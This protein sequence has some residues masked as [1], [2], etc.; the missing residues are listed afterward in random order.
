MRSARP[1]PRISV[2]RHAQRTGR[3]AAKVPAP[4]WNIRT[5]TPLKCLHHNML[6]TTALCA[7]LA[8]EPETA[9]ADRRTFRNSCPRA[10]ALTSPADGRRA[11]RIYPVGDHV[12]PDAVRPLLAGAPATEF[13]CYR[14]RRYR[15]FSGRS[16]RPADRGTVD[17]RRHPNWRK[18][19]GGLLL[20]DGLLPG[21][22]GWAGRAEGEQAGSCSYWL[23][24]LKDRL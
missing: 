12:P 14:E 1:H 10:C 16:A 13:S 4:A 11:G 3:V 23:D 22:V 17:S 15:P 2:M 9:G 7:S 21:A 19:R 24:S 20:Q 6:G 5:G 8:G 18:G